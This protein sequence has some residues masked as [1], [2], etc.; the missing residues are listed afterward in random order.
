M[1]NIRILDNSFGKFSGN[2]LHRLLSYTKIQ[3]R[4][5]ELAAEISR[6]YQNTTPIMIGIL[7]G[8]FIFF[9]DL[10]RELSIH[11]EVDF[12]KISSYANETKTSG[13]V[14]LLKDISSDISNREIIIVEDIIDSGL[15][16]N[17]LKKRLQDSEAKSVRIAA[18]LIK[19]STLL[20]FE[21]DYLGF[22]IPDKFVVGYG[23]DLAQKMRNLKSI[24]YL[25]QKGNK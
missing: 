5:R 4:V 19:E 9:A 13:T 16:I 18:L 20:D 10:F 11:A 12:I 1:Q 15:S 7:N 6:D 3:K 23:L 21:I 25:D 2:T 22:T 8:S 14:R 17:F 24:Y